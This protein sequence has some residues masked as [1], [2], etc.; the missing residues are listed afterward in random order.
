VT[1]E[2]L[3]E[4]Y[5]RGTVPRPAPRVDLDHIAPIGVSVADAVSDLLVELPQGGPT[6]FR[7]LTGSF[8]DRLEVVVHFLAVLELYKLG[9]VELT[10]LGTF[11]T[12]TIE[13]V[14]GD[15]AVELA[16]LDIYEG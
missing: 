15:D 7:D 11:G 3:L 9:V 14:G 13:W 4:A 12:I 16:R 8:V 2:R 6:T 5:R 1:P 10:Q